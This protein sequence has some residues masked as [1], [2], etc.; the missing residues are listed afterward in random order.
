MSHFFV[1]NLAS[2][3]EIESV[4]EKVVE[5]PVVAKRGAKKK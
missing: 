1:G 4:E 5:E 2:F 3:L